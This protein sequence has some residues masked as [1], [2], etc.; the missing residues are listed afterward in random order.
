MDCRVSE[1]LGQLFSLGK[2]C[3]QTGYTALERTLTSARCLH[4]SGASWSWRLGRCQTPGGFGRASSH[5]FNCSFITIQP[6]NYIHP[7]YFKILPNI[8][9]IFLLPSKRTLERFVWEF[10]I[11][12]S[13]R[14][15]SGNIKNVVKTR[16]GHSGA[17]RAA[18]LGTQK[19]ALFC[20]FFLWFPVRACSF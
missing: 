2:H 10:K 13:L 1:S 5:S 15:L 6:E 4:G 14:I 7:L 16:Q 8:S 3:L 19:T 12:N 18:F 11:M 17:A 9:I 20:F